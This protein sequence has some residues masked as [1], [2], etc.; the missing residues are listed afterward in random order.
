[1]VMKLV[2]VESPTKARTLSRY[3]GK[4]YE[5]EASMGHL[6]DLP[7]SKLSV[8]VEHDFK[9]DYV[10][11]EAKE[12][13]VKK[14]KSLAGKASQII[15]SMDPDRE[16]EAIAYHIKFLLG[17]DGKFKRVVF[18]QITKAAIQEAF[19]N[20][21]AIDNNLVEAQQ[22]RRVLD[23]LVGYTL[24]P[25]LWR[26]VRRGLSAGRVQSVAVK[27]IVEREREIEA[28]I[29][30]EHWDISADLM[31][32][33]KEKDSFTAWLTKIN[34]KK[35]EVSNQKQAESVVSD[36]N[37]FG[38]KVVKVERKE[39]KKSP[40]PPFTTSTMQQT[41]SN[42]LRMTAKRT[43]RLAQRL[44][45]SGYITYHRTDS[46]HLAPEAIARARKY[47]EKK[48]GKPYLPEKPRM[49]K[50]R[51]K[52]VQEAHEAIRPTRVGRL[53]SDI[54]DGKDHGMQRLYSIIWKRF[55]ASQMSL[56][57]YDQTRIEVR[58][59]GEG[60]GEKSKNYLLRATGSIRKF[61]GWRKLYKRSTE[62]K[63]V[64][65]VTE[66]EVLDLVK[67]HSEQKFS[68]PPARYTD[69]TLVRALEQRGIG[70]PSTYAPT[71]STILGRRYVEYE[72]RKFKPTPVGIATNDFL[73][74]NFDTI[75]DYDFT[76]GMEEDLDKIAQG[77]RKWVPVVREFWE[78]FHKKSKSVA[79]KAK[80][81]EVPTE[82]TGKKCP[83]CKEGEAVIR[84][85]RF[86]KF[87][88]CSTFPECKYTANFIEKI[89][90]VKCPDD[91]GDIVIKR[92]RKGKTFYGCANYP[93]CKWA[94]WRRPKPKTKV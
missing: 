30:V 12:K 78:P 15:L 65:E 89:K 68:E 14:L 55:V 13:I 45:E 72:E 58:A 26:K 17:K 71:I 46:V 39:V 19:A 51:S 81:V 36:L 23:R 37:G 16:G 6:R 63:D 69:A 10:V 20:P 35:A 18:H 67:V 9:P 44:Y 73:A 49:F 54:S 43:M 33:A 25:L 56:S 32:R 34:D 38:Y 31:R 93:K 92:T 91:G 76:A 90:G 41:A 2:I 22:A 74:A 87:L 61:D 29:P 86:G 88:S 85:G 77:K 50:G 5:I 47:I 66:A 4:G 82:K 52:L 83:E 3:L 79:K 94:S 64:P 1:M 53:T 11:V 28:F 7:K 48:Y 59:E 57:V 70:R 62:D 75:I 42:V 8:D 60:S 27:L 84:V 24:S 40:P 80:R 21:R